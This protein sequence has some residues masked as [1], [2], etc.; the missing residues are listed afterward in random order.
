MSA[1][2]PALAQLAVRCLGQWRLPHLDSPEL[3]ERVARVAHP[4]TCRDELVGLSLSGDDAVV[5]AEHR[6]AFD[7]AHSAGAAPE[8][9]ET[10]RETRAAQSRRARVDRKARRARDR[11]AD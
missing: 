5:S 10:Q 9:Q 2:E 4:D 1:D 6:P 8:A 3:A 11:A 7:V